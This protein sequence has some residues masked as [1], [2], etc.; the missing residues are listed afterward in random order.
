MAWIAAAAAALAAL[1]ST[2]GTAASI[3]AS[4]KNARAG[5]A[6][7]RG[8]G[9]GGD[10]T[11]TASKFLAA[12]GQQGQAG[13]GE[14]PQEAMRLQQFLGGGSGMPPPALGPTSVPPSPIGAMPLMPPG[15]GT[16]TGRTFVPIGGEPMPAPAGAPMTIPQ[17]PRLQDELNT[18]GMN[19]PDASP[20]TATSGAAPSG[21]QGGS[22]LNTTLGNANLAV[23]IGSS[24]GSMLLASRPQPPSLPQRPSGGIPGGF[25]PTAGMAQQQQMQQQQ[26]Q[27]LRL[28]RA[29]GGR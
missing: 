4:G 27:Q 12:P 3:D 29:L 9:G 10:F 23:N 26:M 5:M 15:S 18:G 19:R 2:V 11:S 1:A 7:R 20:A 25:T 16:T 22:S 6:S 13:P 17:S 28:R 8:A 21:S 14:D 24:L